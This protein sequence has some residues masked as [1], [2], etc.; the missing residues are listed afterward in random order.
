MSEATSTGGARIE[1]GEP[2][3]FTT[4]AVVLVNA[5]GALLAIPLVGVVLVISSLKLSPG[6][7]LG[8]P[9]LT[10]A[11]TL[12]LLPFGHGNTYIARQVRRAHP[13][14]GQGP[15][16]FIVQLTLAPR[17]RAGWRALLEDADDIGHLSLR[18]SSLVFEGDSVK[19]T[20]PFSQ[21]KRLQ[22]QNSGLRG[23]FVYGARLIVEVTGLPQVTGFQVA[24]RSSWL[25]PRSR[26]TTGSLYRRLASKIG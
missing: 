9:L 3:R 19:L 25:L 22:R 23:A 7:L 18:G 1:I 14:A 15:E 24:E 20:V 10:I 21:I 12:L 11:T 26:H 6:M 5:F 4:G 16:D 17:I 8:I 13:D 2:R